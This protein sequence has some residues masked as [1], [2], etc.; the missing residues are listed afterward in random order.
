MS[1]KFDYTRNDFKTVAHHTLQTAK[2]LGASACAVEVSE[3]NGLSVSSRNGAVETVEHNRDKSLAV[4]VYVGKQ[5]GFASTS[6][7]SEAAIASTVQAAYD[8]ARYTAA[9]PCAGLPKKK[10]LYERKKSHAD[11]DLYHPWDLTTEQAI[12]LTL[13]AEQ[14][15]FDACKYIKNSDGATVS[16]HQGH[17]IS[18]A[19][20]GFMGGHAYSR[21]SI[22][23]VPI[24]QKGRQMER[25]V[26]YTTARDPK[27]LADVREMGAYAAHRAAARLGAR[28]INSRSCPVLFEAPLAAGLLGNFAQAISGGALYRKTSF[29]LD[30]LGQR[31]FPKHIQI[32]DDPFVSQG[33]GSSYFD[34]EGVACQRRELVDNGRLTGYLLSMYT[35]RKLKMKPTGNASGSHNLRLSSSKTKKGDDFAAMLRKMG[36]GLLVTELLGSGVNY[37]TGDY[38]RGASGFWVENGVIVHP[39]EEITIAGNLKDMFRQ[40]VAVGAD[41]IVRGTKQTGSILIENMTIAG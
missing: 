5:R 21:H 3:S 33:M 1:V 29:L 9:D 26:W 25:D 6:D 24:A 34:D 36:T 19:S 41:E 14:A 37:V 23:C 4:S 10:Y 7:F 12:E 30:A 28:K 38:S 18:A 20:N 27:K 35:A 40:I 15:A 17:F 22:S 13:Q 16:T 11:L 32:V 2:M 31:I 8:I 39:V